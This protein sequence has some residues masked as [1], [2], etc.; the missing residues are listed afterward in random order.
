VLIVDDERLARTRLRRLLAE[1]ND[2]EVIGAAE[3][4][5]EAVS[6][7]DQLRPD[8]LFL[9]IQLPGLSG[10]DVLAAISGDPP[11]IIFTTAF[12]QYAVRAFEV[13]A[14]DY[15]LKPFDGER[16]HP[17]VDRAIALIRGARST[18]RF[19]EELAPKSIE[20]F[21]VRHAGRIVFVAVE[22]IDWIEAADNYV[23]L[24]AGSES[25][26]IRGSLKTIESRL[27]PGFVRIHRSAIVNAS[28]IR[29]LKPLSH[30]DYDV[31]LTS[32]SHLTSTRTFAARLRFRGTT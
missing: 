12:D 22:Q 16:L 31:E 11:F 28:R 26:L 27:G 25:H 3:D 17:A 19:L 29:S 13:H 14:L 20:R 7:I 15:L 9:D 5:D 8:L 6:M 2:V 4:G 30:G 18:E 23:Y 32:G 24:H 21:V 1:R 10:F